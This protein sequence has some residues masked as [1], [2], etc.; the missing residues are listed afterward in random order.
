M[1][2]GGGNFAPL[3]LKF[4]ADFRVYN[5]SKAFKPADFWLVS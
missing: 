2:G 1:K 4:M 3:L 5:L